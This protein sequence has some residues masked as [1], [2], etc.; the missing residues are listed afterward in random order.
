MAAQGT[1]V[2]RIEAVRSQVDALM[3]GVAQPG[4]KGLVQSVEQI[5]GLL[6]RAGLAYEQRI[7]AQFVGVHP[8]NRYGQGVQPSEVHSLMEDIA[9][10]GWSWAKVTQATFIELPVG[11]LGV[12]YEQFN[13]E[14]AAGSGEQL[15]PVAPGGLRFLSLACGHTNQGLRAAHFGVKSASSLLAE[16]GRLSERKISAR[17]P[18][19]GRAI[20]QGLEWTVLARQVEEAFP[21]LVG[22]VQEALNASDQIHRSESELEVAFKLHKIAAG[23]G[24][25]TV[26]AQAAVDWA[27]VEAQAARSKPACVADIPAISKFVQQFS[28]GGGAP[29]LRSLQQ[30]V[31]SLKARRVVRGSVYGALAQAN[32]GATTPCALFRV[33]CLKACYACPEKFVQGGES[34]L[35]TAGDIASMGG[36]NKQLCLSAEAVLKTA[37][38]L[39]ETATARQPALGDAATL[40]GQ[41]E[42]RCVTHVFQKRDPSR[43][44]F[45]SLNE[46]GAVFWEE[47]SQAAGDGALEGVTPPWPQSNPQGVETQPSKK[48]KAQGAAPLRELSSTGELADPVGFMAA[49]GVAVG[50]RVRNREHG[51]ELTIVSVTA[52]AVSAREC[53]VKKPKCLT[54]EPEAFLSSHSVVKQVMREDRPRVR[55]ILRRITLCLS[56][57]ARMCQL[58]RVTSRSLGHAS[59]NLASRARKSARLLRASLASRASVSARALGA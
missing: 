30:F 53:D 20:S 44:T 48:P 55:F 32:T 41:L 37:R 17:D 6:K 54:F 1:P 10:L 40:L 57:H 31:A 18:E 23:L 16:N 24:G 13:A 29:M 7:H 8:S 5:L 59:A 51:Q 52:E 38:Q 36:R 47:L 21:G 33:A 39:V 35:L 3:E 19:M 42:V 28:G 58:I 34:N 9:S 26:E 12:Q 43:K 11:P 49:K 22:M 46:I 15:A 27:S 56:F 25:G 45:R 4:G 50:A 14:L 2:E